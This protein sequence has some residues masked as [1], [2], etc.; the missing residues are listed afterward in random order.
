MAINLEHYQKIKASLPN[1]TALCIVSKRHPDEDIL[2]YYD[3]G[4]RIFAENRVQELL[5][6]K[7]LKED[8]AWHFIGHLQKNKVK[9]IVPI[10]SMIQSVD[11]L[12]LAELLNKECHKL[13][14][15][16]PILIEF[17]LALED[18]HKT[19]LLKEEAFPFFKAI[20]D[21]EYLDVK[22]IMVMGPNTE[23]E[24]KIH[25]TF[26]EAHQLFLDLQKTYPITV[27]SM[28]MSHD[29]HIAIQHGSTMVRIGTSL[30]KE[31]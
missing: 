2:A 30:F 6:K 16:L 4:E 12:E 23:D 14:K 31:D 25:D 9:Q 28:G 24:T 27:L 10:V 19:G 3:L 26:K 18:E 15:V 22:G 8:I 5:Q 11:S 7:D 13:N 21:L 1:D 20:Q 29:Y 17:H